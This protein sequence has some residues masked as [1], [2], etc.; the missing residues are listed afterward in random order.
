MCLIPDCLHILYHSS[1]SVSK[2]LSAY[3][4]FNAKCIFWGA[5]G[6]KEAD[7]P[8]GIQCRKN[9]SLETSWPGVRWQTGVSRNTLQKLCC[10]WSW[11]DFQLLFLWD[12]SK[13]YPGKG[14]RPHLSIEGQS[15]CHFAAVDV[16]LLAKERGLH[17]SHPQ[18]LRVINKSPCD[19][20]A[21]LLWSFD[22]YLC[23]WQTCIYLKKNQKDFHTKRLC[24]CPHLL[25][26]GGEL[27][28]SNQKN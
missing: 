8:L 7:M 3:L 15:P 13:L 25:I 12:K 26:L 5:V 23:T 17:E 11:F 4:I 14:E 10:S 21:D 28:S 2:L 9:C 1:P 27:Y 19:C 16:V 24:G 22:F 20:R 6:K 18:D